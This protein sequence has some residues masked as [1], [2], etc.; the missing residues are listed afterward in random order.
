MNSS[1][2]GIPIAQF[3]AVSYCENENLCDMRKLIVCILA[4]CLSAAF[5][6]NISAASNLAETIYTKVPPGK[7]KA[8][9]HRMTSDSYNHNHYSKAVDKCNAA[10][11]LCKEKEWNRIFVKSGLLVLTGALVGAAL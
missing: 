1:L 10:N 3:F 2:V 6:P 7:V 9:L 11:H 5:Y 4:T 8:A